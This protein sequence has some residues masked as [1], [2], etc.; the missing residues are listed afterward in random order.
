MSWHCYHVFMKHNNIKGILPILLAV[1]AIGAALLLSSC[2]RGKAASRGIATS[3]RKAYSM[4]MEAPAMAAPMM[5]DMAV[6]EEGLAMDDAL[7]ESAKAGGGSIG[8]AGANTI[9]RKL[10]RT[11]NITVEVSDLQAAE[12]A[13]LNKVKEL[14]GYVANSSR[15][16]MVFSIDMKVPSS[17][18]DDA[19]SGVSGMGTLVE[20]NVNA[21][22]VTDRYYDL[23]SRIRT[24]QILKE[25]LESYL[26]ESANMKDL[27][28]VETQLNN[29]I[30]DLESMQGQFKRLSNQIDY[31]TISVRFT[32]PLGKTEHGWKWPSLKGKARAFVVGAASFFST[33]LLVI[34]GIALFGTPIVLLCALV[35]CL[36]FGK[37]GWVRRLFKKMKE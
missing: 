4:A 30:S 13:A 8:N 20:R 31:S 27:V 23:D 3:A 19:V 26:K 1:E 22:D 36:T 29:V 5:A 18:F 32:L 6:A 15:S 11:A 14:G 24:K 10:I 17:L 21:S 25:R 16:D 7:L 9:E 37:V 12:S 2:G 35:Y 28:A 33:L 34:L